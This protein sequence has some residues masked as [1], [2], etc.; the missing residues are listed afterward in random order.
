MLI[1]VKRLIRAFVSKYQQSISKTEISRQRFYSRDSHLQNN[2]ILVYHSY[3][4]S[5]RARNNILNG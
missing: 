3:G 1:T 4:D 2:Q 5:F